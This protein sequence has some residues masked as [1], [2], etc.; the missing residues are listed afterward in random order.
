[1]VQA[2]SFEEEK[3]IAVATKTK[4]RGSAANA[5]KKFKIYTP[6]SN[7][8]L[9][10][11]HKLI[12]ADNKWQEVDNR[13]QVNQCSLRWMHPNLDDEEVLDWL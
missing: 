7:H 5:A 3:K 2:I 10:L 1:M 9:P 6:D 4:K 12:G 8:V 11:L 13:A